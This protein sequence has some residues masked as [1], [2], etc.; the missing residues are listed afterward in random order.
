MRTPSRSVIALSLKEGYIK[1][2]LVFGQIKVKL[3]IVGILSAVPPAVAADETQP[4]MS[5]WTAHSDKNILHPFW[6]HVAFI[7]LRN[8]SRLFRNLET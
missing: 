5:S 7:D 2:T 8:I 3:I 6:T 4:H 1:I